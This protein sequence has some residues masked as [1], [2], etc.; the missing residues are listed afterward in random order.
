MPAE[1]NLRILIVEDDPLIAEDL[2]NLLLDAGYQV[3]IAHEM[4]KAVSLILT[5]KPEIAILDINLGGGATGIDIAH[6]IN[7]NYPMPFIYLTS[8]AD[9]STL[10]S[11]KETH[12]GSYLLKPF[13]G[14]EI[15]V[16]IE[17]CMSNFYDSTSVQA[18]IPA[19]ETLN[20]YLVN[21]LS[22][23]EYEIFEGLREGLS[24]KGLSDKLFISENTV[25]THL[26]S[27]FE[28]LDVKS[29]TEAIARIRQIP[30]G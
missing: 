16:A 1:T 10:K 13:T 28:K 6:W 2:N 30:L 5:W 9:E 3:S 20:R 12:P 4:K 29:R 25:K 19:L 14:T 8:Y 21:P 18:G 11:A 17:I 7:A 24:N 15:K 26:K 27:I 23:R 22:Q